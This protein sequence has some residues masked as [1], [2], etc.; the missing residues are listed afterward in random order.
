MH[1]IPAARAGHGASVPSHVLRVLYIRFPQSYKGGVHS[2]SRTLVKLLDRYGGA[3]VE[4]VDLYA[5]I[6]QMIAGG[7]AAAAGDPARLCEH[8]E[9]QGL[10]AGL[11]AAVTDVGLLEHRE[12]FF[13]AC[14]KS[15]HPAL[16]TF[17]TI[18][19]APASVVNLFPWFEPRQ[20]LRLVR[21]VR[22]VANQAFG[23]SV[24]KRFYG[25][26]HHLVTLTGRAKAALAAKLQRLGCSASID[27]FKHPHM[28]D[29]EQLEQPAAAAGGLRIGYLGYIAHAKGIDR[30][31]D[32]VRAIK[33]SSPVLLEGVSVDIAG[34]VI[35]NSDQA[36]LDA[37][38]EQCAAAGLG[39]TVR[40]LGFLA[41]ADVPGFVAGLDLMVLPY[42]E[43]GSGAASGPFM[44]A[45]T[46]GVPVLASNSRNF[47]DEIRDGADGMLFDGEG[48]PDRLLSFVKEESIRRRLEQGAR[49]ASADQS[50]R[51]SAASLL[52]LIRERS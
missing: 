34:G 31:I 29:I 14:L 37:L 20:G 36:Y 12:F 50:W 47:A 10:L 15:R 39:D 1:M 16:P 26:G 32:A 42:R 35:S 30:L 9:R 13:L 7:D 46:F 2:Y 33:A 41:S 21:A 18:H 45:R 19:D 6:E 22:K 23:A 4:I 8:L 25:Q 28:A 5:I 11:G 27:L 38:R 48:L 52:G 49:D 24:E 44:W 51:N 17:A 40:F 43:T 3:D